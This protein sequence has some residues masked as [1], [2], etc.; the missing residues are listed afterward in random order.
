MLEP[1]SREL[2]LDVLRPPEGYALDRAVGTS[3]TLDLHAL[4]FA[5]LAF[6]LFDWATDEAGTPSPLAVLES[7]RRYADRTTL[8]CQAGQ[9]AV[10]RDYQPLLTFLER[11]VV[12]LT[13]PSADHIFHP[14]VWVLRFS[15]SAGETP[16][17]RVVCSSRNVT[18]DTSWD[19][20][21]ALDGQLD[22]RRGQPANQGLFDFVHGLVQMAGPGLDRESGEGIEEL[23]DEL[24][25]A[26][27]ELPDGFREVRFHALGLG[28]DRWPFPDDNERVLVVSPFLTQEPLAR[29][30][31][32]LGRHVLVSREES[33]DAIGRRAIEAFE[34][35]LVVLEGAIQPELE[36]E[37]SGM[38]ASGGAPIP[39]A[40]GEAV[41]TA[42]GV[43]LAG[44]HAKLY[45]L[46]RNNDVH[47]FTGSANATDAAFGGNVEFLVELRTDRD[48]LSVAQL[49]AQQDGVVGFRDLLGEYKPAAEEPAPETA[50]AV[51]GR[52]LAI[53]SRRLGHLHYRAVLEPGDDGA[54]LLQLHGEGDL[55][56]PTQVR[57]VRCWRISAGEGHAVAPALRADGLSASFGRIPAEG[58][59]AFFAI[60]VTATQAE[61]T[62]SLRFV[63]NAE[64][65][66][67]PED[68]RERVLVDLLRSRS[69][70]L[71]YLLFLLSDLTS[72]D[73]E[74]LAGENT[75]A[76]LRWSSA[77]QTPLFEG[78]LVA[79][80]RD[81]ERLD[82][83]AK[84]VDDLRQA[85][86]AEEVLPEG[87]DE[88]W[89][90][91]WLARQELA[92]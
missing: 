62:D 75:G 48:R 43:E 28:D 1:D 58:I 57:K 41:A 87:F 14:K 22:P 36:E 92:R 77:G 73:G 80:R 63:V 52:A 26:R 86:R 70:V 54:Y 49:L 82:H 33:L 4:L 66:G 55:E 21:V 19:T 61:E 60:E 83:V 88:I 23:A 2:L 56:L 13:P 65:V 90:P 9:I 44:L 29:L 27:F 34:E 30:T 5:P 42:A 8:F 24:A 25:Y 31:D 53:A 10:P 72:V 64:L 51:L 91:I 50:A 81:P 18:F 12:P 74:L 69:D 76:G 78:L 16:R 3:F 46:E 7:L 47:L 6:A 39:G 79:L 59:T 45:V 37:P 85:G 67:A 20:V 35:T 71:R 17:V 38:A 32:R 15:S 84:L 40:S 11:T 89:E 68:R